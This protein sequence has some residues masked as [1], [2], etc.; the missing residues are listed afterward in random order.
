MAL[1]DVTVDL[2]EA[3]AATLKPNDNPTIAERQ[4]ELRRKGEASL[5]AQ[6]FDDSKIEA[7]TFYNCHFAK[8]TTYLMI[9]VEDGT[10]LVV[11]F[12]DKHFGLFGF[13]LEGRDILVESVRVR[14]IG[15]SPSPENKTP[16]AELKSVALRNYSGHHDTQRI[17][18]ENLGWQDSRVIALENLKPGEQVAG[19][20]II[21]D[22]NQTILVEPGYQSTTLSKHIVL[23]KVEANSALAKTFNEE[24]VDPIQLSVFSHRSVTL[25]G[26]SFLEFCELKIL[27]VHE[28]RRTDGQ[29]STAD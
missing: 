15:R 23:D 5:K 24:V 17:Y 9:K 27:Q 19:P 20:A 18:F 16:F 26:T 10:D 6:G 3:V 22:K 12:R 25:R 7:Q 1:S 14:A 4:A 29:R 13:V 21:Y 11:A 28:H 8:A 2:Q